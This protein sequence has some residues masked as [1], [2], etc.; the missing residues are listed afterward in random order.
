MLLHLDSQLVDV[1]PL[2]VVVLAVIPDQ[3]NVGKECFVRTIAVL[4]QVL[5]A[6]RYVHRSLDDLG[7]ICES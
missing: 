7:V 4:T 3:L 6:G 2:H 1:T 5:A